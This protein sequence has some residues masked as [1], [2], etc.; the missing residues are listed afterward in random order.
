MKQFLE[1]DELLKLV[2][3]FYFEYHVSMTEWFPYNVKAKDS[4]NYSVL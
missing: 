4:L 3:I 2:D 1:D